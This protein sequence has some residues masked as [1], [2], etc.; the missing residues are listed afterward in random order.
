MN[1]S[2][3]S[4]ALIAARVRRRSK[5]P[6]TDFQIRAVPRL[7]IQPRATG[8]AS[9]NSIKAPHGRM[10]FHPH[11]AGKAGWWHDHH[12]GAAPASRQE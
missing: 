5:A 12:E 1:R 2:A 9:L 3:R 11:N 6:T 8:G 7:F 4:R 10:R